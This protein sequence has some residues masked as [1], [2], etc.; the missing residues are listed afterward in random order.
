MT[1]VKPSRLNEQIDDVLKHM[2]D[3]IALRQK[4]VDILH[5]YADRTR[6]PALIETAD[7]AAQSLRVP[8]PVIRAFGVAL[9]RQ[10]QE[11]SEFARAASATLWEA[12]Y[13][14][15]RLLACS[16]LSGQAHE[17]VSKWAVDYVRN[18]EDQEI[19]VEMAQVGIL[20][21]RKSDVSR[22][23]T[24]VETW[25]EDSDRRIRTFAF[26]TLS[27]ACEDSQFKDIPSIFRM[28]AGFSAKVKGEERRAL[29]QLI[30]VLAE[31]S[32]PE[33]VRFLMD[34]ITAG[35]TPA[36]NLARNTLD[37]FPARQRKLLERT[38]SSQ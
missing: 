5:L 33:V 3:P 29:R 30:Q 13:R 7:E 2:S 9:K 4:C 19:I 23:L 12:G 36:K 31:R 34:E 21:W 20:D 22:F 14:E 26:L 35:G 1:A 38:L 32:P 6:R 16:I 24:E 8:R 10:A 28:V 37:S 25:L 18:C 11:Q 17:D 27:A 15:T